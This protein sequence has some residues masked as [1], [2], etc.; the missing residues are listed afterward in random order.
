MRILIAVDET[1]ESIEAIRTA[2]RLFGDQPTYTVATIG[3]PSRHLTTLDPMGA[4]TYDITTLATPEPPNPETVA[5][6]AAE[7]AGIDAEVVADTG[8]PGPRLCTLATELEVDVLVVGNHDRG[9]LSRLLDPSVQH[10]A[11]NHA[12]CPVLIAR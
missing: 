2:H 7:T 1:P 12:P 11:T 6:T 9:F 5:R 4:M 8:S 10:Y 3:E